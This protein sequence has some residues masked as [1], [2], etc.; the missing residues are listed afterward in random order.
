MFLL[1]VTLNLQGVPKKRNTGFNFACDN[2]GKCAPILTSFI[3]CYNYKK[4][5][6]HQSKI[7]LY[8]MHNDIMGENINMIHFTLNQCF[9]ITVIII[10][11][12]PAALLRCYS[13]FSVIK[14][15]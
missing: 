7:T 1:K 5:M 12:C 11:F 9:M 15:V 10:I 3:Y 2:I 8:I 14:S 4:C 6:T 13:P